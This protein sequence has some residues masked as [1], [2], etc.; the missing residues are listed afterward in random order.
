MIEQTQNYDV[1]FSGALLIK[2]Q[3]LVGKEIAVREHRKVKVECGGQSVRRA[4]HSGM[5]YG[6]VVN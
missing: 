3:M 1:T 6:R 5:I 4:L 2:Y